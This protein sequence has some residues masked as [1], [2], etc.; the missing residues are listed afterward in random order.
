MSGWA[1]S[2]SAPEA[3]V[4]NDVIDGGDYRL[5]FGPMPQKLQIG[6]AGFY[7]PDQGRS[8]P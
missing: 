5:R 3:R 6:D 4:L 8:S 1:S 7:L 2:G